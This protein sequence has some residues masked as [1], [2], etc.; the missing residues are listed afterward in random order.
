MLKA[1]ASLRM[2]RM[3][4]LLKNSPNSICGELALFSIIIKIANIY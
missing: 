3:V 1:D 2:R 4:M